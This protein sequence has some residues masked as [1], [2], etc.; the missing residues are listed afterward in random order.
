MTGTEYIGKVALG[1]VQ[2]TQLHLQSTM[3]SKQ[4][5]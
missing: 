2:G 3:L 1:H 5:S 4:S